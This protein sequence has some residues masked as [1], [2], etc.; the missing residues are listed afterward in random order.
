MLRISNFSIFDINQTTVTRCSK[1]H[2]AFKSSS[3]YTL[4]ETVVTIFVFTMIVAGVIALVANVLTGSQKQSELL[5]T[6]DQARR[7]SL[8]IMN[9]LRDAIT[10]N[11]GA[12]P[13]ASAGD[14]ELIFFSNID[15]APDV[16]RVRYYLQNGAVY[17]GVIKPSG[18]P[19]TYNPA[20]EEVWKVQNNVANGANP[21]FYYYDDTYDGIVDNYL[22]QPVNNNLVR[23]VKVN[24]MI[25]NTG[26][27]AGTNSYLVTASAAI[28]NLKTNLGE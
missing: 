7:F 3:G 15:S 4:I 1:N 12:Y 25:T 17:K 6:S 14:F 22:L 27:I 8:G 13:V 11:S 28:R 21:L 5:A 9:E 19:L 26:G 2:K 18:N 20:L 16:E 23:L 24:L 10:S